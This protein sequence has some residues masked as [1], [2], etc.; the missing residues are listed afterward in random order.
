MAQ[1]F[2]TLA[3][4]YDHGHDAL[5]DARSPSE[6]ALDHIP[7]AI[8]LPVLSDEE[9]AR[10][11]TIHA[12]DSAFSAKKVG[13]ALVA[14]NIAVHLDGP[15]SGHDGAWRPLVYCWRGGQRSG[16]FATVLKQVG[17]RADTIEGGYR[18]YRRQVVAALYEN[19]LPHRLLVLEGHTGTGKTELLDI[20]ARRGV[21]VVDLEGLA[22]HRGSVFG[23][24]ARP[25]PA[26]PAFEGALARAFCGLDPQRPVL[27]EA[28][29]SKIGN[30]LIP[31]SVWKAMRAAPRLRIEAPL[32]ARAAYLT[33]AYADITQDAAGLERV[34]EGLIRH[35]GHERVRHWQE[36]ARAGDV[37]TLASELM[38]FHYDPS[39][40]RQGA[41][42]TTPLLGTVSASAL[43]RRALEDVA[44]QL[45]ELIKD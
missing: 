20:L 30:L 9:R 11:G 7:G 34:L 45:A 32:E 36:L 6:Y 10:V 27:V 40:L 29:S 37:T 21:Q 16:A 2:D 41:R 39:Y 15:L 35:Q 5:I 13:A 12:R 3:A 31:P 17:W 33:R 25:Q 4:Y 44:G 22:A 38:H 26:Q 42:R 1:S 24:V 23:A 43:D 18:A 14:R 28:E 8:N 19:P